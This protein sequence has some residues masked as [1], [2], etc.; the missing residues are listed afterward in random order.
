MERRSHPRPGKVMLLRGMLSLF[1]A[2]W[3]VPA[4]AWNSLGH[5]VVAEIAWRELEPGK[6]QGIVDVLRRHPRLD[7]DFAGK[8]RGVC[9]AELLYVAC[10]AR[11]CLIF[12]ASDAII[13]GG[14]WPIPSR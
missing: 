12:Q 13:R 5:K 14:T 9:R 11:G 7:A 8:M 6:R 2:L 1:G 3:V 4:L 10:F